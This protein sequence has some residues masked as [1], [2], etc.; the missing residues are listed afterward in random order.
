MS[1]GENSGDGERIDRFDERI[2]TLL[3]DEH[4]QPFN[5]VLTSGDR[6]PI[7]SPWSL[8]IGDRRIWTAQLIKTGTFWIRKSQI[9]GIEIPEPASN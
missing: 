7:S 9:V 8:A 1:E 3:R 2:K 5:I 4:F 6:I